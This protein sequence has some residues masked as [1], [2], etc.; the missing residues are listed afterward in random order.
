MK[1]S[2]CRFSIFILLLSISTHLYS[3]NKYSKNDV[4]DVYNIDL[5]LFEKCVLEETNKLRQSNGL[6]YLHE[7]V[8]LKKAALLHSSQMNRYSFFNHTNPRER[9]IA[10]VDKRLQYYNYPYESYAENILYAAIEKNKPPTYIELAN[11]AVKLLYKS[12]EHRN[13]ILN[14]QYSDIGIGVVLSKKY[15]ANYAYFYLT[16]DFGTK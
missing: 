14:K 10:T 13:N 5:E 8:L 4:I 15:D 9:E 11:Y 1:Q 6:N 12:K 2:N 7:D 16:Q 3:Q